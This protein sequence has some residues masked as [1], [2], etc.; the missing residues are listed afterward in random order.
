MKTNRLIIS[1]TVA[2]VLAIGAISASAVQSSYT[3]EGVYGCIS[4]AGKNIAFLQP[5]E[6]ACPSG[7]NPVSWAAQGSTGATGPQGPQ[8]EKGE[9]G[10]SYGDVIASASDP[11]SD[12]QAMTS[13]ADGCTGSN[14]STLVDGNN[15]WCY[16]SFNQATTFTIHSVKVAGHNGQI[17][18]SRRLYLADVPCSTNPWSRA[19]WQLKQYLITEL[20]SDQVPVKFGIGN[21]ESCMWMGANGYSTYAATYQVVY[22]TE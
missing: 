9:P 16:R 14:F 1:L 22:S 18:D 21:S 7:W 10:Y 19:S 17:A 3:A 8:G 5:T 12:L 4:P 13:S 6:H 20:V 2:G 11:E 15:A